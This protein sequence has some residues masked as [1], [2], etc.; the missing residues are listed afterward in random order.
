VN[1]ERVE[2]AFH[3]NFEKVERAFEYFNFVHGGFVADDGAGEHSV[4]TA[5]AYDHLELIL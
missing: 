1:L 5:G 2:I 4:H 3:F